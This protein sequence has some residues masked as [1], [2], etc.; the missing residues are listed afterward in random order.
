MSRYRKGTRL[1]A[2]SVP[3]GLP[4]RAAVQAFLDHHKREGHSPRTVQEVQSYLVGNGQRETWKPLLPWASENG[5]DFLPQL[6]R[7]Q[8]EAYAIQASAAPRFAYRKAC[9]ILGRFLHWCVTEGELSALPFEPPRPKQLRSE[10]RVFTREEI[11][12]VERLLR[13]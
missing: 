2:E 10:I 12:L 13:M 1:D 11:K 8:L 3:G 6:D 4:I 7:P 5:L 9:L